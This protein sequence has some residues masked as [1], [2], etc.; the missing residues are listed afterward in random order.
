MLRKDLQYYKSLEYN[1][2]IQREELDGDVWY[3]AYCNELGLNACHGIGDNKVSALNSFL[4]EKDAFIEMLYEKGEAI[5]EVSKEEFDYKG[6]FSV[7]T[8]SWIHS[9]LVQQA[10]INGVS[11][12]SYINQ[13]LAFG[14]GGGAVYAKCEQKINELDTR[15]T[16]QNEAILKKLNTICY[17]TDSIF[18]EATKY[19]FIENSNE[20]PYSLAI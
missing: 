6:I 10:K 16:E 14:I 15:M 2:I 12:N 3:V 19:R 17:K 13:I 7:R 5:P 20:H 1:I 8:S 18:S 11:L 9:M 4:E